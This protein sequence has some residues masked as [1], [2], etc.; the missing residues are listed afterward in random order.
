MSWSLPAVAA[1]AIAGCVTDKV[2]GEKRF[3]L[4]PWSNEQEQKIGDEAAPNF[5]Q[6][7]GGGYPDSSTQTYLGGLVAEMTRHSVRKD[8]FQWKFEVLN[9]SDP[10]AFALPGGYVYVTRG[11]LQNLESEGEFVGVLGHELGHVEHQHAMLQQSKQ[12]A[13]AVVVG[14]VGVGEELLKKD[15]DQPSTV[16]ALASAAAPLTILHF[17][18][19]QE[20]E[21]DERGVLFAH[22]MNYDPREMTKT[23]AYFD[24]LERKSGGSTPAFLRSHPTNEKRI[25]DIDTTIRERYPEVLSKPATAFR[26]PPQP[27]DRFVALVADL[28]AKAPAYDKHDQAL[29]LMMKKGD[30]PASLRQAHALVDEA[31]RQLPEEPLFHSLAG[32]IEYSMES[33]DRGRARFEKARSLQQKAGVHEYW[34]PAFYLGAL[35]LEGGKAD[36]ALPNLQRASSLFPDNP[37]PAYYLARAHEKNRDAKSA[38][39]AYERVVALTPPDT[40]LHQ[41]ALARLQDG[42]TAKADAPS[43]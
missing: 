22:E 39:A 13:A 43:R 31:I 38:A 15:P 5:E 26:A 10:N 14:I 28:K 37:V 21:A 33:G 18:R 8:D 40:P 25:A 36:A 6:Q 2:T 17:S 16:T 41:K 1:A 23:F 9:S 24:R 19:A 32:E 29:A 3:A 34:K 20:S 27:K 11:L 42:A 4:M 30:D 7:F 35:D 12:I